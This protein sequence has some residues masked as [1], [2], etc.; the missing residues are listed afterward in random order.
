MSGTGLP[1]RIDLHRPDFLRAFLNLVQVLGAGRRIG[2]QVLGTLALQHLVRRT[3][4]ELVEIDRHALGYLALGRSGA[5]RHQLLP[6]GGFQAFVDGRAFAAGGEGEGEQEEGKFMHEA[7]V[8]PC[9]CIA[10]VN[11][12]LLLGGECQLT[13]SR[14]RPLWP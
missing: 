6:H 9:I 11:P 5:G 8:V 1:L 4:A 13:T 10:R 14:Q 12:S 3:G 7:N 2:D